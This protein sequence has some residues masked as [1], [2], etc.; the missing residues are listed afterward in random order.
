MPE[1][2]TIATTSCAVQTLCSGLAPCRPRSRRM[3][4]I[5][6]I[7]IQDALEIEPAGIR[8]HLTSRQDI[9]T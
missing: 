7:S 2:Q 6:T 9:V 5:S 3:R 8:V 1:L 4:L